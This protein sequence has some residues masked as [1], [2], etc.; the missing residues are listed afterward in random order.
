MSNNF[1]RLK[2]NIQEKENNL[3][4]KKTIAKKVKK[5]SKSQEV[6]DIDI[7]IEVN[8]DSKIK[9]TEKTNE[10]EEGVFLDKKDEIE[11]TDDVNNIRKKRRRSSANIE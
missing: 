10:N 7:N 2:D 6:K 4:D 11:N 3:N 9:S 1:V 8:A 5:I